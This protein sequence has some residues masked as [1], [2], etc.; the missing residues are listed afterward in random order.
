MNEVND[1]KNHYKNENKDDNDKHNCRLKNL[2]MPWT[3]I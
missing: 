2:L 3:K 1:N